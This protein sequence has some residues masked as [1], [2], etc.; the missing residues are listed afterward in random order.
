MNALFLT[1]VCL[2]PLENPCCGEENFGFLYEP[3]YCLDHVLR[4][5][6]EPYTP[7][8]G[9]I[10]MTTDELFFWKFTFWISFAGHPHHSGVVFA[11]PDGRLGLLEAG[12]HDTI[13]CECLDL[14]PHLRSYEKEG[15]IWVRQRR[16]PLTCEQSEALTAFAL[17]QDKKWFALARLGGQLTPFRSRGPIKTYFTRYHG[18]R[19]TYWCGELAMTACVEAGLLDPAT[20]RPTATYPRDFF[21]D[22]S[23]NLYNNTHLDLSC[24]WLPPARWV[25][26]ECVERTRR[27][28]M[29]VKFGNGT[30]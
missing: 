23:L 26:G 9:D 3:A 19:R 28:R 8:P 20:T 15:R 25:S 7:Q 11:F 1:L 18:E 29:P 5:C 17:R 14:A 22:R 27:R 12:P 24:G 16:V 30:D 2:A 21:F 13:R 4:G 10:V 6:P